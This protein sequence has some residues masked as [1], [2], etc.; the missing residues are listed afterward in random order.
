MRA[1]RRDLIWPTTLALWAALAVA[2]VFA[3]IESPVRPALV[4][5][6]LLV[7]PGLAL[8]RLLG[9]TDRVTELTLAI[10]VSLALNALVP[11]LMLYLG[12]WSPRAGLLILIAITAVATA[13]ET[14]RPHIGRVAATQRA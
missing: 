5:L 1:M 13:Y 8:V 4:L 14:A 3:D 2:A 11:G 10:A 9:I 7:C 6:F 12:A